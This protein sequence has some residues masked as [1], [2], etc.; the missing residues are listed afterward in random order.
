MY[1]KELLKGT[2]SVIILNLLS[3]KGRMYGYEI[4]QQV[5]ERS[6]GKILLKDGSL[7]PALQ[8][9]RKD[10]LLSCEE[11]YVGKR[12]RKYYLLTTKGEEEK[13]NYLQELKDFMETLNKVIFPKLD[14]V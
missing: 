5:K 3:E 13:V 14:V 6:D 9:M 12:V 1:S 8:K 10:G 11:E 2:L 4:F 7:Y